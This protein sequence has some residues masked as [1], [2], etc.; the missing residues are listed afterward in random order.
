MPSAWGRLSFSRVMF[1]LAVVTL[2]GVAG[3]R[4]AGAG[5]LSLAF[6]VVP[7]GGGAWYLYE[8]RNSPPIDLGPRPSNAPDGAA[9][10]G[11]APSG[12][13]SSST[14]ASAAADARPPPPADEPMPSPDEPFDDPVE[15]ADRL[16]SHP[17]SPAPEDGSTAEKPA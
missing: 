13:G 5:I 15:L 10:S 12:E 9:P 11:A 6:L 14:S 16:D 17:G 8:N 1:V 2:A 4:L 7:I 3:L